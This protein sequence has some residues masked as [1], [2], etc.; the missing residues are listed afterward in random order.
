MSR[1][2]MRTIVT[3]Y[4]S[5]RRRDQAV[6]AAR[7]ASWAAGLETTALDDMHD[8]LSAARAHARMHDLPANASSGQAAQPDSVADSVACSV[9]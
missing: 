4:R 9:W 5:R 8:G 1:R 7:M 2:R 3:F 6:S